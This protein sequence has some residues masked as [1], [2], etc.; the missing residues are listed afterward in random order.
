MKLPERNFFTI[1]LWLV[2]L[3]CSGCGKKQTT[4]GLSPAP[5]VDTASDRRSD[6]ICWLTRADGLAVFKKQD[7]PL[8]FTATSNANVSITVDS[9]QQYQSIDGFGCALT[10][11]SA[12]LIDQLPAAAKD[13][14][15]RELFTTDSNFIGISYLRIGIGASDL[16]T[17][18]YSY[19]DL[20]PGQSDTGLTS[21]S[22]GEDLKDLV[23]VLQKIISLNPDIKILA[24]PWSAPTWMKTNGS[25]IGGSLKPECY[26]VYAQYFVRYIQSMKALGIRIDAVTMQNEPLNPYNNPSMVMQAQEQAAFLKDYLGPAFAGAGIT[27]KII[28]NENNP[29]IPD[30]PLSILADPGAYKYADGS[31]FHLYGGDISGLSVVHNAYPEKNVYFTE[32]WVGAPGDFSAYLNSH[33]KWLIIGATRNWSRNVLEWNLAS[34]PNNNPHTT[35][36]CNT[37]LGALTIGGAIT[38]NVGYY[39]MAHASKFVR[40][41]SIR[42][43]STMVN[44]L[45]NTAFLTPAG[46]KVLIV[47]NDSPQSQTFNIDYGGK[48]V[49][50]TLPAG[51]VGTYIW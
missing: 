24:S 32:Q 17:R 29:D 21:F 8:L 1:T 43:G 20:P 35:G 31:A 4:E 19:D 51:A 6:V 30:Y 48:I 45:P 11:G 39:I 28:L 26:G 14:L 18:V 42:I 46:K 16:S 47:L 3:C 23:P 49:S 2:I 5:P 13:A 12:Y 22:L 41:G 15:L 50:P 25:S 9:T 44:S 33:V 7:V 36:G 27:A 10:Q 40:P 37:C 38:R 34:D